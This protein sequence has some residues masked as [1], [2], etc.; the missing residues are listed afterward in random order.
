MAGIGVPKAAKPRRAR[1][2]ACNFRLPEETI[3]LLDRVANETGNTRTSAL[4]YLIQWGVQEYDAK[5]AREA[6][7]H[8]S[9][10]HR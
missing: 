5:T 4:I 6:A 9:G 3:K 2:K 1:A 7:K 8:A 10:S